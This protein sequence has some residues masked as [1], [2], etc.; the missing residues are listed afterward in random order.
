[1]G[2]RRLDARLWVQRG[3]LFHA[4]PRDQIRECLVLDDDRDASQWRSFFLPSCD[5]GVPA[6]GEGLVARLVIRGVFG[7]ELGQARRERPRNASDIARIGLDVWIAGRMDV[8][9]RT[10]QA[11]RFVQYR[12]E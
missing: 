8:A 10:I 9:L 2:G 6:L 1:M 11:R 5:R 4:E 7:I 12:N 3:E